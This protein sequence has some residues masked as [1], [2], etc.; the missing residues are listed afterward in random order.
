MTADAQFDLEELAAWEDDVGRAMAGR[1]VEMFT[2]SG[3]ASI[4][5][6]RGALA[7]RDRE[8][9]H[10]EAHSLKSL[11]RMLGARRLGLLSE[12]VERASAAAN[13]PLADTLFE[14]MGRE[15]S[16]AIDFLIARYKPN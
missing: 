8:A 15:C 1:V 6:L 12:S 9:A 7:A 2:T 14:P 13:W 3:P 10:R 4:E 16:A 11:A 5:T